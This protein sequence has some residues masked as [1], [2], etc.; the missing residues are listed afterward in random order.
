MRTLLWIFFGA[1]A[2]FSTVNARHPEDA[3]S[4]ADEEMETLAD[5]LFRYNILERNLQTDNITINN[6]AASENNR[7][8]SR[9]VKEITEHKLYSPLLVNVCYQDHCKTQLAAIK[10]PDCQSSH[11]PCEAPL[12][13]HRYLNYAAS[14]ITD[15]L[16]NEY[17]PT[18]LKFEEAQQDCFM[19][20][21]TLA[22]EEIHVCGVTREFENLIVSNVVDEL[23][24]HQ[25]NIIKIYFFGSRV[26][27]R[28]EVLRRDPS[29][30]GN[31]PIL[32]DG[33]VKNA[34]RIKGPTKISDLE[35]LAFFSANKNYSHGELK[36]FS[37][38][39]KHKFSKL[40]RVFPVSLK[41]VQKN[42]DLIEN[43][44]FNNI[45]LLYMTQAHP[46]PLSRHQFVEVLSSDSFAN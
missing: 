6:Q 39:F 8:L 9:I 41:L 14:E 36:Q 24:N 46:K 13:T 3:P 29:L 30:V 21:K 18:V 4:L 23:E 10:Y 19:K 11:V 5:Y 22:G 28:S 20:R 40:F 1:F 12:T 37:N 34:V 17:R 31:L 26:M 44:S 15:K 42:R 45:N 16:E 2:L 32:D 27:P 33:V 25:M 35:I 43:D 7:D 38:E